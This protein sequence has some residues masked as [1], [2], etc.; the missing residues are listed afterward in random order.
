MWSKSLNGSANFADRL[1][2]ASMMPDDNILLQATWG[3]STASN[4]SSGAS[5]IN[6]EGASLGGLHGK[7]GVVF[8][9]EK[10]IYQAVKHF[11]TPTTRLTIEKLEY[12][13]TSGAVATKQLS[14]T[15]GPE[16]GLNLN[17][18]LQ[19]TA[20]PDT[21]AFLLKQTTTNNVTKLS[22]LYSI[23][24]A[25]VNPW[26]TPLD[27]LQDTQTLVSLNWNESAGLTLTYSVK[28]GEQ[29]GY[30][31]AFFNIETGGLENDITLDSFSSSQTPIIKLFNDGLIQ[32]FYNK[33][34]QH[35]IKKY[36]ANGQPQATL[37][38]PVLELKD[39]GPFSK[40][41]DF[42]LDDQRTLFI[43]QYGE[44]NYSPV[45]RI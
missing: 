39:A 35:F 21:R 33:D 3:A 22:S 34:G 15:H 5:I 17:N 11:A 26:E 23:D 28:E 8:P 36:A 29:I 32:I 16:T 13:Y 45:S 42:Y 24:F 19:M 1:I 18:V 41:T 27:I 12:S 14:I 4:S 31:R 2:D 37:N 30:K 44:V 25:N 7:L 43:L 20:K 38:L 9:K 10:W 40:I 6:S